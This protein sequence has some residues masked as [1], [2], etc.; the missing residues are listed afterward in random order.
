MKL[1]PTN[2]IYVI[3]TFEQLHCGLFFIWKRY[4]EMV[5]RLFRIRYRYID[6]HSIS[7]QSHTLDY[8]KPGR[9]IV[10]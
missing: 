1:V 7:S 6:D 5:K 10:A 2:F 8:I 4:Y 3:E 9:I